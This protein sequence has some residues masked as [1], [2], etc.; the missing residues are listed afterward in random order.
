M[1]QKQGVHSTIRMASAGFKYIGKQNTVRCDICQLEVSG[2]TLNMIPF[3]IHAQHSPKCTFVRSILFDARAPKTEI[4]DLLEMNSTLTNDK[5]SSRCQKIEATQENFQPHRLIELDRLKQIRKQTFSH[6]PHRTSPSSQQMINAGFFSCNVEDRV[7]CLYC[8]II[9]H[10]WTSNTDDP[11]EV[12]KTLSPQ[13]PYV[14]AMLNSQTK[15]SNHILK[16]ELIKDN[17]R[18]M[19][20]NNI[21]QSNEVLYPGVCHTNYIEISRRRDS[22]EEWPNNNSPS[23]DD[24]VNAGFFYTGNKAIVT[25]FYCNGSLEDLRAND[26]PFTEHTRLF[27][28]CAFAK[29]LCGAELYREIQQVEGRRDNDNDEVT[30]SSHIRSRLDLPISKNLLAR[31]FPLSIIKRCY[32]AQFD[33]KHDDF[34]S[35]SDLLVACMILQKQIEPIDEEIIIPH[36][37]LFVFIIFEFSS[38]Y[39]TSITTLSSST[40]HHFELISNNS[41]RNFFLR[42]YFI[43]L[44]NISHSSLIQ[45]MI[46]NHHLTTKLEQI[47][48]RKRRYITDKSF[49]LTPTFTLHSTNCL[50][51][52][53]NEVRST[54]QWSHS[55]GSL[56]SVEL[57]YHIDLI[58]IKKSSIPIHISLKQSQTFIELFSIDTYLYIDSIRD[59]YVLNL[60]DYLLHINNQNI[61]IETTIN[62][63]TCQTLHTYIIISLLKSNQLSSYDRQ[64]T[65][66]CKVK[67]IQIKFEELGLA[68]L[69]IRPKEYTF[70]YCDGNV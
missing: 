50:I 18:G 49:S 31:G 40:Y 25:C 33:L 6:W 5:K 15:S 67:T 4:V 35:D 13:C 54:F 51:I 65:T 21:C 17:S 3:T 39:S 29:E 2:W 42:Q 60:Y 41:Y 57:I 48:N 11:C 44:I 16:E 20:N 68:Y 45:S 23:V 24:L 46:V 22:F 53:N 63:Q 1:L 7:I 52:N 9:C 27:S 58:E 36:F 26:N 37:I 30:F 14:I 62:N 56:S 38:T 34:V 55:I 59:F 12:H 8:N 32:K 66:I 61:I 47:E 43:D 70:T 69:I 64:K 28:H 19:A 10:A